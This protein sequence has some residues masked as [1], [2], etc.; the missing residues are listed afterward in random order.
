M[1][2]GYTELNQ[3]WTHNTSFGIATYI[4]FTFDQTSFVL[5]VFMF[6]KLTVS[7]FNQSEPSLLTDYPVQEIAALFNNSPDCPPSIKCTF[8]H[9]NSWF[10]EFRTEHEALQAYSYFREHPHYFHGDLI[11]VITCPLFI[12]LFISSGI[13]GCSLKTQIACKFVQ[14]H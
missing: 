3:W 11:K 8:A 5:W 7:Q 4:K 14:F 13:H 12:T 6:V 9:N 10:V 1:Q 2:R